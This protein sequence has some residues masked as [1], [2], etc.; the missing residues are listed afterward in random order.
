MEEK[1][2]QVLVYEEKN[3]TE[4]LVEN[5]RNVMKITQRQ[6]RASHAVALLH[7][8][9]RSREGKEEK[10]KKKTKSKDIRAYRAFY[11]FAGWIG[12][13]RHRVAHAR[14]NDCAINQTSDESRDE[15]TAS[16][17]KG[18]VFRDSAFS[19]ISK[20]DVQRMPRFRVANNRR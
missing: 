20:R 16:R 13:K 19:F 15:L 18:A 11:N 3:A 4:F 9:S 2:I 10:K 6:S 12:I 14:R 5:P 17:N 8:R 7:G 1:Y